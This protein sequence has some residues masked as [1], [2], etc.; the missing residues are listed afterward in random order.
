MNV[1]LN[2]ALCPQLTLL[3][4]TSIAKESMLFDA[5]RLAWRAP[6]L[7]KFPFCEFEVFK[8]ATGKNSTWLMLKIEC[9]VEQSLEINWAKLKFF[10]VYLLKN[11]IQFNLKICTHSALFL[12]WIKLKLKRQNLIVINAS[13]K[14][15]YNLGRIKIGDTPQ[16]T[17]I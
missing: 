13:K 11:S 17:K 4:K 2:P 15:C 16:F 1:L 12:Q 9:R 3:I 7:L 6:L 5:T 10:M 8:L 14:T